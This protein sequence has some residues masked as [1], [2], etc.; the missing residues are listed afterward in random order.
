M[1][2]QSFFKGTTTSFTYITSQFS[3]AMLACV[4]Y[5]LPLH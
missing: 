4:L 5:C 3:I 1:L 2:I